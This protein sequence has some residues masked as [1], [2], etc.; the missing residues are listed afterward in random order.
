M[1][2]NMPITENEQLFDE[3]QRIISTTDLKGCITYANQSFIQISGFD[4][5]ELRGKSHNIVRHPHMPAEAFANLWENIK[6]G[7]DWMGLVQNRC[8]NGDF[9]WVN[10]YVSPVYSGTELV[11]YQSVRTKPQRE[12]VKQAEK[13]YRRIRDGRG[14]WPKLHLSQA[15]RIWLLNLVVMLL[16]A[17]LVVWWTD[18]SAMVG[19]I[20]TAIMLG[21]AFLLTHLQMQPWRR[22]ASKARNHYQSELSCAA[23]CGDPGEAAQIEVALNALNSSKTTMIELI[24]D[25]SRQLRDLVDTTNEIVRR[26]DEGISQQKLDIS[27]LAT[28]ITEMSATIKEVA[29]NALD[30]S[31][32]ANQ[33]GE[34]ADQGKVVV[35]S[36]AASIEGLAHEVDTAS[37]LMS[38]LKDDA[39]RINDVLD[40][41]KGIADQTNLLALN[42]A[43]EASRAGE[44]GRGFAVVADEVRTLAQRTQESTIEIEST[45]NNLNQRVDEVVTA[46]DSGRE[47]ASQSVTEARNA[48]ERLQKIVSV[49]S[50]LHEMNVQIATATEEQSAVMEDINRTMVSIQGV[51]ESLESTSRQSTESGKRLSTMSDGLGTVVAHFKKG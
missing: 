15:V 25:A 21:S 2:T 22:L 1:K 16:P 7:H 12:Y 38:Q 11:G 5:E 32:N 33:A 42:A 24:L 8:K 3:Y 26:N 46:M 51:A 29:R 27:Q 31:M 45:I 37:K 49:V 35:N 47:Q 30:T 4:E 34:E 10:A 40:V 13:T 39:L 23:Y 18:A 41:I 9:Y 48:G 19:V 28:A 50:K 6:A 44:S 36:A 20:V 43:I 14:L 17:L